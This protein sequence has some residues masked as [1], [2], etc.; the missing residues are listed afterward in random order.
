MHEQFTV[1]LLIWCK[2]YGHKKKIRNKRRLNTCSKTST[3]KEK[4]IIDDCKNILD[5]GCV[6]IEI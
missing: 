5:H 2:I 1:N 6:W 3:S 4:Y